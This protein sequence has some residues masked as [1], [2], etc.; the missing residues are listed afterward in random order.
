MNAVALLQ[1]LQGLL[2]ITNALRLF[3]INYREVLDA[4]EAAGEE[5]L[6]EEVIQGFIDKAQASV[7]EL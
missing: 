5:G 7:D 3:G 4:Q 6:S 1:I 2:G